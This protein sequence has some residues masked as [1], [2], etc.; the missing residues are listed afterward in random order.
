MPDVYECTHGLPKEKGPMRMN[1]HTGLFKSAIHFA[2]LGEN[3][4]HR[5]P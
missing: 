4:G 2:V 5:H 1:I 3:Q